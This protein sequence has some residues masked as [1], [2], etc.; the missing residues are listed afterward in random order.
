[1]F[2]SHEWNITLSG[3]ERSAAPFYN[4]GGVGDYTSQ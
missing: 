2:H 3:S 4:H 1:M